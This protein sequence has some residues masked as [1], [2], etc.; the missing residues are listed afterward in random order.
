MDYINFEEIKNKIILKFDLTNFLA[1]SKGKSIE[2]HI[3]DL[4]F[5]LNIFLQR[6][7]KILNKKEIYILKLAI[8]FHDLGKVNKNFQIKLKNIKV[9][10]IIPHNYISPLFLTILK[11][12]ISIE[13]FQL[14]TYA[15]VNHH[16]RGWKYLKRGIYGVEKLVKEIKSYQRQFFDNFIFKDESIKL[17]KN[18]L[19]DG[20]EKKKTKEFIKISGLLIR[21]D[22]AASGELEIEEE[23]IK[24]NRE[25]L[26]LDYL[27]K[28][29]KSLQLKPFQKKFGINE[30]KDYQCIVA[31]T[32]LGKT[33]LSVLWS[34][35]KMF[36]ILPNRASVNAMYKTLCDIYGEDKVGLL[37]STALFSLFDFS[38]EK[39]NE[40]NEDFNIIKEYEQTLV[41]AK[42]I[43]VCTADQLFIAAFNMPGY[44]K[45][46]A[47]LAYS[48]VI[49]D[50]IQG[51]QPQQIIPILK[52]IRETK[53]LGT[54]YLI[55]TATLPDIIA[56]KLK[57]YG[58]EVIQNDKNT[59]DLIKRHKIKIEND[60]KI[61]DLIDDIFNKFIKNK[62]ILVVVNTVT[63]AQEIYELLKAKFKVKRKEKKQNKLNI[64]HSRFIWKDRQEKEKTILVESS[65]YEDGNYKNNEGCIWITTQLVEV[66]LDIDFE[67]L[68]TEAATADALIQRM[69]R[70]WR[71][72]KKDYEGEE[73]IIIACNI[74]NKIY[75]KV[76][77]QQSIDKIKIYLENGYL[78][79]E[80]KRQIVKEIYCEDNLKET[81]YL[82]QWEIFE[83]QI[84][85]D[86]QF[87][88]EDNAQKAFRDVMT[89]ELV[90]HIYKEEVYK[91]IDKLRNVK[92]EQ[93][94]EKIKNKE[95]KKIL[96]QI[97]DYKVP[98]P[99]YLIN[100]NVSKRLINILNP[101][102][103]IE[104][105]YNIGILNKSY[106]YDPEKG[107][108]GKVIEF[109]GDN[110]I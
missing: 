4:L 91:L 12:K 17:Y 5:Q 104:N 43:T 39:Q 82:E 89:V 47:T 83:K 7:Y 45:I 76:L 110:L 9:D 36:Y 28:N 48:D 79:S 13:D 31:D 22:H 105:N 32:G 100:P 21:L 46:Y 14:I 52:Q 69:G 25:K 108:T 81:K 66:S 50:E 37:H 73:N 94:D 92:D 99:I 101:V 57:D 55:I 75:E 78:I 40:I 84:N 42:P 26:L 68:F 20:I 87:I 24:K 2:A 54:K 53:E 102:E 11:E 38:N 96:K 56:K 98:V 63:K 77:V 60:N 107:L 95:R 6:N 33:G 88:L 49:I 109:E 61:D 27:K 18:W 15:I 64:L 41:L 62:K 34:K 16:K 8:L 80:K 85:S 3:N 97:Q 29:N 90:P 106:E 19:I 72:K 93:L 51:F 86:W 1:K 67:Y 70:I 30:K 65:Q 58:F 10:D 35:R 71:H 44:E 59:I 103:W 23:P 74:E